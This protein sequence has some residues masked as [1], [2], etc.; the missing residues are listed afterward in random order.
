MH[1][2]DG[3][4]LLRAEVR[5]RLPLRQHDPRVHWARLHARQPPAALPRAHAQRHLQPRQEGPTARRQLP[6]AV[7]VNCYDA[8]DL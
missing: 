7:R 5:A 6:Y 1:R 2:E 8:V 3:L 4:R